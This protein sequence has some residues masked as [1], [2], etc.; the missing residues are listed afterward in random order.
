MANGYT[1]HTHSDLEKA[2]EQLS[3]LLDEPIDKDTIMDLRQKV[4]DKTVCLLS[5]AV[6]ALEV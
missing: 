6:S 5:N 3:Q 4:L 1:L 2:V